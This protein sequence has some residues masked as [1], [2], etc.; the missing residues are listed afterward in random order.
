MTAKADT[1]LR[2]IPEKARHDLQLAYDIIDEAW[3]CHLGFT[4]DDQ[5]YVVPMALARDDDHILLHGSVASRLI[6]NLSAGLPC[7]LTITH[8][9][10]LVLARSAFNSSM[11]YRSMMVFGTA[12]VISDPESKKRGFDIL[13][14]SLLPGRLPDLRE[15][16]RQEINATTLLSLPLETYSIKVS[17]D[18]PDDK[19]SDLDAGIWAGVLPLSIVAGEPEPAPDLAEGIPMPDYL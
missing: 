15:S 1:R 4:L 6:K 10:G 9:D 5:P 3:I 19:K 8:L 13:T 17:D 12:R 16:T 14:E 18:P 2:R 7:C 11:H